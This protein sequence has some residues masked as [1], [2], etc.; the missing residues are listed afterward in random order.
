MRVSL[1]NNNVEVMLSKRM[2]VDWLDHDFLPQTKEEETTRFVR[3][4]KFMWNA[5]KKSR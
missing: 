5:L 3:M 4:C 2:K 1:S